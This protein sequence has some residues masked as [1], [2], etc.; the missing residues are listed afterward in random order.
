MEFRKRSFSPIGSFFFFRWGRSRRDIARLR[1]DICMK[2]ME[3]NGYIWDVCL[4]R[5][6]SYGFIFTL[7]AINICIGYFVE[8]L[9]TSVW[10][11]SRVCVRVSGVTGLDGWGHIY[12][13]K[14]K[15]SVGKLRWRDA[16]GEEGV[17]GLKGHRG[18]KQ[19]SEGRDK[20]I[21]LTFGA[22]AYS[23]W[24]WNGIID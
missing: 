9:Q 24:I 12:S 10:D 4:W 23:G 17:G 8:N 14:Q 20:L 15:V 1:C 21:W 22:A 19:A 2:G 18:Q 16:G 7:G 6:S 11:Q 13:Q 5:L 3:W